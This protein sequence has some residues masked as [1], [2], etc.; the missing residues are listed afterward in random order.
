MTSRKL[1][2]KYIP[3]NDVKPWDKNPKKHNKKAVRT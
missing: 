3:I 2:I 1:E